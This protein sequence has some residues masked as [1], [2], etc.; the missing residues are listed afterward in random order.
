[1][2]DSAAWRSLGTRRRERAGHGRRS[3]QSSPLP[4]AAVP[5]G[6][7]GVEP[8]GH[9]PPDPLDPGSADQRHGA[10]GRGDRHRPCGRDRHPRRRND[11]ALRLPGRRDRHDALVLRQRPVGSARTGPKTIEDALEIRRRV[12]LAFERAERTDD[13]GG[14]AGQPD[15]RRRRRG[16]DRGRDRRRDRRDRVPDP[17]RQFRAIDPGDR[18]RSSCSRDAQRV[19]GAYPGVASDKAE[20]QLRRSASTS[21]SASRSPTSTATPCRPPRGLIPARTVIWAA[22]NTASPLAARL[23]SPTDRA[24]R[25]IV[26]A[27]LSIPGRP[28]VFAVGDVAHASADGVDVPGVA[29]GRDPGWP[30]GEPRRSGPISPARRGRRSTTGT[31]ASWP[32]SGARRR[33]ARSRR[34]AVEASDCQ[35]GSRGWRG[36]R[37]TSCS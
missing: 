3:S 13:A 27:D 19:L 16:P 34:S 5:G 21:D 18:R 6:H 17:H 28:H 31:R 20:R 23:G 37:S 11:H 14:A 10:A 9:R 12:L 32:R 2:A 8:V 15:V 22:G 7:G 36:G 33:S 29:P 26:E 4:P 1:M 24:G 30:A 25:V 35:G